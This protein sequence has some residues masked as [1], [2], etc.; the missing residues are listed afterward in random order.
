LRRC[1]PL[2]KGSVPRGMLKRAMNSDTS[3]VK[4]G[5]A[6]FKHEGPAEIANARQ[7]PRMVAHKDGF[8]SLES[9]S[10]EDGEEG[11]HWS[12]VFPRRKTVAQIFST[13]PNHV[14]RRRF[15][16][17]IVRSGP[18]FSRG[19][20]LGRHAA[21]I[22]MLCRHPRQPFPLLAVEE[23]PT[24]SPCPR[25]LFLRA[26]FVSTKRLGA[27]G[28]RSA[29]EL[30]LP[31]FATVGTGIFPR[32]ASPLSFKPTKP[33]LVAAVVDLLSSESESW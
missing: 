29:V 32:S 13:G 10:F 14:D 4:P 16:S 18:P 15:S 7:W 20:C 3:Q 25:P 24:H 30:Q 11:R 23:L 1:N 26:F 27:W 6:D 5:C 31:S 19:G 22:A 21:Q 17:L 33:P 2:V 28:V 8:L 9:P 12:L